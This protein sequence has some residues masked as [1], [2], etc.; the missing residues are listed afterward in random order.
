LDVGQADVSRGWRAQL[1]RPGINVLQRT[2]D[3]VV[4]GEAQRV[5]AA[6]IFSGGGGDSVFCYLDTAAP[7]ADAL[8]TQGPGPAFAK[9]VGDLAALHQCTLWRAAGL[10]VKKALRA[11]PRS[12]RLDRQFLSDDACAVPAQDHPWFPGPANALPGKREQ[13]ASIMGL[14]SIADGSEPNERMT[15]RHPLLSQPLVELCLSIPS[16]MWITGGRNRAVARDAFAHAL[17]PVILGR[18]TKGDFTGFTADIFDRQRRALRERL[19]GG[20]LAARGLLD[21]PAIERVLA[22]PIRPRDSAFLRL[23]LFADTESWIGSW[24]DP[25]PSPAWPV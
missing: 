10:A 1:A 23:L 19:L 2:V 22:E 4:A 17:P 3:Q 14:Q 21:R 9:A 6:S 13:I 15:V 20:E 8:L 7:A 5:G 24:S 16:W 12:W 18:R 25:R 11:P